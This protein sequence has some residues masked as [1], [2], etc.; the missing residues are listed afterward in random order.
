MSQLPKQGD[1]VWAIV[2]DPNGSNPKNRRC[3]VLTKSDEI[4]AG[5]DIV[6]AAISTKFDRTNFDPT[7]VAAPWQRGGHPKTTLDEPSVVK[8][9]WLQI[10]SA[11][12]VT[13]AGYLPG[14]ELYRVMEVIA[15]LAK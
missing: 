12:S 11:D 7:Y 15:Q 2:Y 1:I 5:G 6:V 10:V 9:R 14:K 8:C 4:Q 13:V 3:L